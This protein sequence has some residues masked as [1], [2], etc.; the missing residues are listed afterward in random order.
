MADSSRTSRPSWSREGRT[1]IFE[2]NISSH[3]ARYIKAYPIP[4]KR[5]TSPCSLVLNGF[6]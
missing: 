4:P 3:I 6:E 2:K 5:L 1:Y